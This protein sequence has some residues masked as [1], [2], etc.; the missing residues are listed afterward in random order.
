MNIYF[1]ELQFKTE[2][3]KMLYT[4][5]YLRNYTVKWFQPVLTDFLKQRKKN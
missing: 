3:D 1:N 2:T 5:T 4:I